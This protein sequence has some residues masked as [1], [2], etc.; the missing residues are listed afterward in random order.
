MWCKKARDTEEGVKKERFPFY[1]VCSSLD[2]VVSSQ[3]VFFCALCDIL[4][5]V[6]W[7][8]RVCNTKA[9]LVLLENDLKRIFVCPFDSSVYY[10]SLTK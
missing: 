7:C 4:H 1:K 3:T 6:R 9:N 8:Y 2:C 5:L 10:V